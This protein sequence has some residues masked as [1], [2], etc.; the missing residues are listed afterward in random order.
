MFL[1]L[2]YDYDLTFVTKV[3]V[4]SLALEK[5]VKEMASLQLQLDTERE[6]KRILQDQ[7]HEAEVGQSGKTNLLL[8]GAVVWWFE[9]HKFVSNFIV[10]VE[11]HPYPDKVSYLPTYCG[12]LRVEKSGFKPCPVHCGVFFGKVL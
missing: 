1:K 5:Q 4:R 10:A 3:E 6:E 11:W 9:S 7:L 12:G 8:G 2:V